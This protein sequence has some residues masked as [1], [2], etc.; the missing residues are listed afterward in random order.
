MAD[1][2]PPECR[3]R[4]VLVECRSAARSLDRSPTGSQA[5]GRFA[6]QTTPQTSANR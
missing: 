4:G 5:S 2:R 6:F 1:E 3:Q